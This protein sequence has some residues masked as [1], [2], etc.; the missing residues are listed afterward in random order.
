MIKHGIHDFISTTTVIKHKQRAKIVKKKESY[1]VY[2]KKTLKLDVLY[3][4]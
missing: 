2:D 3:A 4:I 1:Y